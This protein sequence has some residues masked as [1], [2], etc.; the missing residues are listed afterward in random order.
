MNKVCMAGRVVKDAEL[1]ETT[2]GKQ[3]CRYSL[4]INKPSQDGQNNADFFDFTAFEGTAKFASQFKKG[5]FVAV[6]GRLAADKYTDKNGNKVVKYNIIVE[7]NEFQ[8]KVQSQRENKLDDGFR[9]IE[10][11]EDLPF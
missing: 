10:S 8:S 9:A 6:S 5:D 11:S 3:V 1:R 7:T 4:A 2:T